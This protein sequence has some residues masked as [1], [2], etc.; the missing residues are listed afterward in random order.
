MG[1]LYGESIDTR[2]ATFAPLVNDQQILSQWV[3]LCLQTPAGSDWTAPEYGLDLRSYVLRGLGPDGLAVLPAEIE[4]AL[5]FDQRISSADVTR[6]K[7]FTGGGGIALKFTIV[8]TPKGAE[9]LPFTLTGTA[10]AEKV[11]IMLRGLEG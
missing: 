8:I 4:A 3:E 10:D 9:A 1:A 7:T 5:K 11:Q 2:S 6:S